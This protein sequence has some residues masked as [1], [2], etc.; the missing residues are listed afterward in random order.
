MKFIAGRRSVIV[1]V[2]LSAAW[3]N[4]GSQ[5]PAPRG[6]L[7]R[8][9]WTSE[10][11]LV[12][13]ENAD[14]WITVGTGIGGE[15]SDAPFD[16]QNPGTI[17]VVQMEPD[18]YDYFL[19]HGEYADGTMFLLSFYRTL[20]KLDPALPGFMQGD[21]AQREIHLIDARRFPQEGRAFYIYR[22]GMTEAP[23]PM[24]LGSACFVCHMEHGDYEGT[25]VQFYPL[26]REHFVDLTN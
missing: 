9:Q 3:L 2:V 10:G 15:Y 25:F 17:G 11:A 13:P 6:R 8:A 14:R 22:P 26:L 21:L 5:D 19:E 12:L 4:A 16:P 23:A 24:P 18:A 7:E 1:A 20:E